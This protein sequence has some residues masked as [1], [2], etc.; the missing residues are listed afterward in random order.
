MT[1]RVLEQFRDGVGDP[2]RG[3][4]N[5]LTGRVDDHVR[6]WLRVGDGRGRVL[7]GRGDVDRFL[8]IRFE[9][10]RR[11]LPPLVA[12]SRSSVVFSR[13]AVA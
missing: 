2:F 4:P 5:R 10:H 1:D 13:M 9:K 12:V 7:D 8:P 6:L 3:G 11:H